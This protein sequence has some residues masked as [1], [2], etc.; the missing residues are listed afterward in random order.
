M[1]SKDLQIKYEKISAFLSGKKVLVAFSGGVDSSTLAYLSKKHAKETLLVTEKSI[2]YSEEETKTAKEFAKK[3]SIPLE[4]LSSNPLNNEEFAKNPK[5]RCYICKKELYTEILKI[6]KK[7]KFDLVVDGSNLDDLNDYRPGTQALKELNIA[8]PYIDFKFTKNNVRELAKFLEL[9]VHSKPSMA[10][11]SSRIPYDQA[12]TEEK[13]NRIKEGESF[14][15]QTFNLAQL[16]VRHHENTLARIEFLKEDLQKILTV[17]NL[18]KIKKK[19]KE[20]GFTYITI[21]IEGYRLGSLNE[22]ILKE[23]NNLF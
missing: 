8:T 6:K 17:D 23:G 1:L 7:K 3:Y 2:L 16:R 18:E 14:L 15:K 4:I 19:F 12:I 10:C 21:D 5:N 13:L 9:E 20:L 22:G 11:F